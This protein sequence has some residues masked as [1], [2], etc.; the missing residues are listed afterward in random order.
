MEVVSVDKHQNDRW[1]ELRHLTDVKSAFAH[2]AFEPGPQ[3]M[4]AVQNCRVL[5]VGAGGL[6]CELLKDLALSGFRRIEVIDMDTIELSNLNRQFLFRETDIDKSKAEVA[7]AFV[8]KR[9]PDCP[10]IAHNCKIEDMDD[11]FYR[12]FDVIICGLDSV[13]ARRWL[14]A[15]LVS[16]VE[17]DSDGNPFG[18]IPLIDG[19]TE[20]FKGSARVILPWITACVECAIDL[21]PPQTS[22]PLCTIANTPRLPEHCIEYV[23]VLQWPQNKPFNGETLDVDNMKHV[24]WVYKAA[25]ERA[26]KYKIE[27]VDLRLTKGVLKRIIPAV[28]STNAVIAAS[29]ALEALKLASNIACPMQNY[30][31]FTNIDGIYLGVV[32]LERARSCSVCGEQARYIDV[33]VQKT[34]RSL[35]NEI[36]EKFQLCNPSV[37]TAKEKLYMKSDLIPAMNEISAAN[38][39]KTLKGNRLNE[40]FQDLGLENGDELLI[41]DETRVQPIS[42][43]IRYREN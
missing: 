37:Q 32:E 38:L 35:L 41:A 43:R 16:L 9:I 39:S 14:S 36:T 22:F 30:M 12:S 8:Q 21:Y 27:G 5:V 6:G 42:L 31:N 25:L 33:S 29:C 26:N 10:V 19:G 18:I 24:D 2:P 20:G 28:A 15:K 34:L 11:Q 17:F 13:T 1:R 23:R 7:A 4:T 40:K 3:N